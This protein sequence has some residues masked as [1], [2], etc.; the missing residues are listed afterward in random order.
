MKIKFFTALH[1]FVICIGDNLVVYIS[2]YL[3]PNKWT[4]IHNGYE[5]FTHDGVTM[6]ILVTPFSIFAIQSWK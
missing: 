2:L 3:K 1:Q 4:M 6:K 5:C